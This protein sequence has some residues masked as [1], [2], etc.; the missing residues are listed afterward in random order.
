M[1]CNGKCYLIKQIEKVSEEERNPSKPF[2]LPDIETKETIFYIDIEVWKLTQQEI[3][4]NK[5]STFLT[6]F[7][8]KDFQE[9]PTPPPKQSHC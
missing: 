6:Q 9:T 3:T 1:Q 5:Q 2:S 4:A 8:S 7:I